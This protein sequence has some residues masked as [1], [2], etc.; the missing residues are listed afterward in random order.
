M[1]VLKLPGCFFIAENTVNKESIHHFFTLGKPFPASLSRPPR[2]N[3][4]HSRFFHPQNP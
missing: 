4:P 1:P 2:Q 3:T